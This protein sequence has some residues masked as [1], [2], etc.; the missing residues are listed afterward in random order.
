LTNKLLGNFGLILIHKVVSPTFVVV[1]LLCGTNPI[2][3][4]INPRV[5][6][7][8]QAGQDKSTQEIPM[9]GFH[10]TKGMHDCKCAARTAKIRAAAVATCKDAGDAV[11]Y[12]KCVR[13]ALAGKGHCDIAESWV[14]EE[15][16]GY[17]YPHGDHVKTG[18]GEYCLKACLRHKCNCAEEQTCDF[19]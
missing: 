12:N 6:V 18:M 19:N 17:V 4:Q 14:P 16:G 13:V 9:C 15:G 10:A 2:R 3:A 7:V 1:A 5:G 11:A 8:A